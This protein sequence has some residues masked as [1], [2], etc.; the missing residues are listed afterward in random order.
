MQTNKPHHTKE[1]LGILDFF[2]VDIEGQDDIVC[3]KKK[4]CKKYKKKGVRCKKCP[5]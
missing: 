5:S 4:C 1:G 3:K 2:L